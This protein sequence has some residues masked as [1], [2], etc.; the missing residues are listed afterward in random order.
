MAN[1]TQASTWLKLARRGPDWNLIKTSKSGKDLCKS[2]LTFSE[3][4][5]PAMKEVAQN[6]YFT[7]GKGEL[8]LVPHGQFLPFAKFCKEQRVKRALLL[9]LASRLPMSKSRDIVELFESLDSDRDGSLTF[10]ELESMFVKMGV[11]DKELAQRTFEALDVDQDGSVT[12]SEF[13]AGALLLFKDMLEESF[14][15]LFLNHDANGDGFLEL[16]EAR[17]FLDDVTAAMNPDGSSDVGERLLADVMRAGDGSK[18]TYEQL[19]NALLPG[20]DNVG[21]RP[22]DADPKDA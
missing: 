19:R 8:K 14:R 17:G 5:R 10:K 18:I 9:E 6:E 13:A 12:F 15:A 16:G 3:K 7:Q 20:S 2:M 1:T 4:S 21:K 22:S 11:N